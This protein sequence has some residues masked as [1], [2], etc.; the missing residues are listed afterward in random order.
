LDLHLRDRRFVVTGAS[1]GLGFAVASELVAEGARVLVVSRSAGPLEAAAERLGERAAPFA[2]DL[3]DERAPASILQAAKEQLG[4]VEGAFVSHGGP[5]ASAASELSDEDLRLATEGSLIAPVR[6]VRDVAAVLEPGGAI[7]VLTSTSSRQPIVGLVG[8]NVTRP[9]AWAYVK[10]LAD[11]VAPRGVR[12][13][14]VL[15]GSFATDRSV[16]LLRRESEETGRSFEELRAESEAGIPLRRIGDPSELAR[17][18]V[19]LLS[20]ASSYVSGAAWAVDGGV[21]RSL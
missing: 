1:R 15:P 4:G 19:F 21:M 5:P 18:A 6:F 10:T 9:G 8:S 7:V 12:V 11:E 20:S 13:N 2:C 3:M 16:E 17:V 14:C